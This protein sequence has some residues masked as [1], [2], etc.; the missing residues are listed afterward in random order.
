MMLQPRLQPSHGCVH[1]ATVGRVSDGQT[2]AWEVITMPSGQYSL[3]LTNTPQLSELR[4]E[5][6]LGEEPEHFSVTRKAIYSA[7]WGVTSLSGH[8]SLIRKTPTNKHPLRPYTTSYPL[9]SPPVPLTSIVT[10]SLRTKDRWPCKQTVGTPLRSVIPLQK[11][12]Q[13]VQTAELVLLILLK[14]SLVQEETKRTS[15]TLSDYHQMKVHY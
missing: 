12:W 13:T 6:L 14:S 1:S 5:L 9:K 11:G 10:G 4:S 8:S 7:P 15:C 2:E 3:E